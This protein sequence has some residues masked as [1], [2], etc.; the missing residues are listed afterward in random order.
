M[1]RYRLIALLTVGALLTVTAIVVILRPDRLVKVT[2]RPEPTQPPLPLVVQPPTAPR[3][4]DPPTPARQPTLAPTAPPAAP[5]PTPPPSTVAPPTATPRQPIAYG[6]TRQ[7]SRVYRE[8]E[9]YQYVPRSYNGTSR[10]RLLVVIHGDGRHAEEYA[11]QFIPFADERRYIILAPYFPEDERFQQLG[12]GEKEKTIRF[13]ERLLGLVDELGGRL[14]VENDR[15]DLFGF[16]AGG[17]FAHRF[18]YLHPERLR[19]VVVASPGT[20]TVPR[21]RYDWPAGLDNLDT[22]ANVRVNL[23]RVRQVRVMLT[24]GTEDVDDDNLRETDAANRWGKTRLARARTLHEE[25]DDARIPHQY[26][27][28]KGLDHE[29]DERTVKPATQFLAQG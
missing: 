7:T 16:S 26:L 1:H 6:L 21:G 23:D 12:I 8:Q 19:S 17:Q 20:V 9:Y 2:Q 13:D 22:L 5:T 24:V 29:L 25:W 10:Y 4:T 14:A 18:L 3:P 28:I 11:E 27:E 15:F